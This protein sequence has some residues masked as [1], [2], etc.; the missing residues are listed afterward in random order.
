MDESRSEPEI[1]TAGTTE[2]PGFE[3]WREPDG[4]WHG[5][6]QPSGNEIIARSWAELEMIAAGARVMASYHATWGR[7]E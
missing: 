3:V 4:R 6:H 1:I 2:I 5:R 7:A